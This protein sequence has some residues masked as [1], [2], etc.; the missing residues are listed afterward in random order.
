MH[1]LLTRLNDRFPDDVLAVREEGPYKDLVAVAKPHAL[2]AIG[3]FLHDDHDAAFDMLT[4]ICSLDYPEDEDRCAVVYLF[5][6]LPLNHRLLLKVHVPE[7]QP[8]PTTTGILNGANFLE[9]RA[10][11]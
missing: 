10:Y 4:D 1:A 5:K 9:R 11:I 7:D 2:P 8:L 6:S 3:R